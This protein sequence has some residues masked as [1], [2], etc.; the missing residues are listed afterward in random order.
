MKAWT[1]WEIVRHQVA[2]GGCVLDASN[3]PIAQ[4]QVTIMSM[5]EEFSLRVEGAARAAGTNWE[6]LDER[7]DR[8][9]SRMDGIFYFLDL[10]AGRYTVRAIDPRSGAKD[11]KSVSVT[12]NQDGKVNMAVADFKLSAD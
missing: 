2:I 10:P 12:R 4:A 6:D 8:A 1:D 3:K 11:E 9:L 7:L 5:P